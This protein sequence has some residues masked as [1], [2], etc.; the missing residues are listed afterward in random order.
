MCI[1]DSSTSIRSEDHHSSVEQI[2]DSTVMVNTLSSAG[3]AFVISKK[4]GKMYLLTAKH[5]IKDNKSVVLVYG[6]KAT[7]AEV[8]SKS[9]K[10]DLAILVTDNVKTLPTVSLMRREPSFSTDS[11]AIGYPY[12]TYKAISSTTKGS[13]QP[14]E[15]NAV[16]SAPVFSGMSGGPVVSCNKTL[17]G[18]TGVITHKVLLNEPPNTPNLSLIHI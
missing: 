15:G 1:R 14:S 11:Y 18:V 5:V 2:Y 12:G 10:R 8:F 17:C 9:L 16:Y 13:Y 3:S 7:K 6:N 4:D